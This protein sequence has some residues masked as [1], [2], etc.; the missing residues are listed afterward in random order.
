MTGETP[1]VGPFTSVVGLAPFAGI[2]EMAID[3]SIGDSLGVFFATPT[4][5]S[6]AGHTGGPL[7][8]DVVR[9]NLPTSAPPLF[10]AFD[11]GSLTEQTPARVPVPE[12]ASVLLLASALAG[13][14]TLLGRRVLLD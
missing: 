7:S 1:S 6:L 5:G 12:P 13:V 9:E 3:D 10:G 2:T 4:A 8:E 14:R 11:S